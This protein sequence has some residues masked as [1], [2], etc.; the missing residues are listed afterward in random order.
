[1]I[2]GGV[3]EATCAMTSP[4]TQSFACTQ[5]RRTQD[6]DKHIVPGI[7]ST[8]T[9]CKGVTACLTPRAASRKAAKKAAKRAARILKHGCD[10]RESTRCVRERVRGLLEGTSKYYRRIV[11]LAAGLTDHVHYHLRP[12]QDLDKLSAFFTQHLPAHCAGPVPMEEI[13]RLEASLTL[14][15]LTDPGIATLL[16]TYCTDSDAC[17]KR[18]RVP[19][20]I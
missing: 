14:L 12:R 8:Q 1:M 10:A 5:H 9:P 19:T 15:A 11:F 16:S 17:K 6:T 7:C 3:A 13:Q 4:R 2:D 20:S 18:T